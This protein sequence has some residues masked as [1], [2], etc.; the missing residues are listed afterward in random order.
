MRKSEVLDGFDEKVLKQLSKDKLLSVTKVQRTLQ[1]GYPR[2]KEIWKVLR[3]ENVHVAQGRTYREFYFSQEKLDYWAQMGA[4]LFDLGEFGQN[5]MEKLS[6][7]REK[8]ISLLHQHC[9]DF[10]IF[11]IKN[12]QK[13]LRHFLLV[14]GDGNFLCGFF[15]QLQM[16]ANAYTCG[17]FF[18]LDDFRGMIYERTFS[19]EEKI[20]TISVSYFDKIVGVDKGLGMM[21]HFPNGIARM[22]LGFVF[23][24]IENP[25]RACEKT[26]KGVENFKTISTQAELDQFFDEKQNS[27]FFLQDVFIDFDFS[28]PNVNISGRNLRAKSLKVRRLTLDGGLFADEL[29]CRNFSGEFLVAQKGLRCG[30]LQ[31]KVLKIGKKVI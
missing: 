17:K 12:P 15:E 31:C 3:S 7:I 25:F 30:N 10:F 20:G 14:Y 16:L 27:Y 28:N 22:G 23:R 9:F 6:A 8:V 13:P 24:E 1:V 5:S 29:D 18:V 21:I 4:G 2:A 11:D 19:C 26:L